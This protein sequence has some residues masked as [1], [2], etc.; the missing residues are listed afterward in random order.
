M[1]K[2]LMG[3]P[4]FVF[5]FLL[6]ILILNSSRLTTSQ[7]LEADEGEFD[8]DEGS[9]R[10]PENWGDLRED[11]AT[12]KT[13][14]LQSPI[15]LVRNMVTVVPE[16]GKLKK[17]YIPANATLKNRGHDISVQ[18]VIGTAG[19]IKI[20]GI[21]YALE[22][23]HWHSPSEHAINGRRFDLELHMVHRNLKLK[24]I[25]VIGVLY[26]SK[27]IW[28]RPD[29]FLSELKKDIQKIADTNEKEVNVGVVDPRHINIPGSKY[30]RY[31]G[32]L[33]TP[34]CTEGV[35]WTINDQLSTVTK[36]QVNLLRRAVD[37]K[38]NARPLQQ[39]NDRDILF[40][41]PK[42]IQILPTTSSSVDII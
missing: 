33:T 1:M 11:W 39:L 35:I 8:Y 22:Q 23:C 4:I 7:E 29:S 25:A 12:C 14:T 38:S 28:G 9:S 34:P 41:S 3:K 5:T 36:A 27:F 30:Y 21:E 2:N 40:Y 32:S 31:S 6:V 18:W 17:R 37:N 16:L 19:S 20:S 10:G 42:H 26:Y 24:K 15:D 13:G